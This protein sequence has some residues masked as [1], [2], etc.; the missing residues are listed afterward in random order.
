MSRND[1]NAGPAVERLCHLARTAGVVLGLVSCPAISV[2]WAAE[3]PRSLGTLPQSLQ[4][5]I[6]LSTSTLDF[7]Q[8]GRPGLLAP[9]Q[10]VELR[11]T[12]LSVPWSV[13][14]KATPLAKQGGIGQIGPERV[15]VR[16]SATQV[17][18]DVGAGP[19][20]VPLNGPVIV[21]AGSVPIYSTP[22]EL[23][24]LTLWEDTPGIYSGDIQFTAVASP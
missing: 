14:A 22:L 9:Q 6:E 10:Q 12:S 8:A 5:R 19:G 15:F 24:L 20:F 16:T 3:T 13:A 7:Q 4:I 21:A 11:V 18:P 17:H 1:R 2:S 23:R